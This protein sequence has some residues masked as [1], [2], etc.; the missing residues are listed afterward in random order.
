MWFKNTILALVRNRHSPY[1]TPK[2]PIFPLVRQKLQTATPK[3]SFAWKK[4]FPK[5]NKDLK[6][7]E[8]HWSLQTVA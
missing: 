4:N 3:L 2:T 5:E 8:T 6:I 1:I 7:K